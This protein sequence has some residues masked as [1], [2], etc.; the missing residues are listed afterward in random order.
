[1]SIK[2][3][4]SQHHVLS[5]QILTEMFIFYL[6]V[7]VRVRV[8]ATFNNICFISWQFDLLVGETEVPSKNH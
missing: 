2:H 7:L 3:I 6:C 4:S 8:N 5:I 1:M